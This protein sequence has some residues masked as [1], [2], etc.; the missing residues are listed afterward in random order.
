MHVQG[1]LAAA[2]DRGDVYRSLT[3]LSEKSPHRDASVPAMN[4]FVA[5]GVPGRVH[6]YVAVTVLPALPLP[7]WSAGAPVADVDGALPAVGTP[8]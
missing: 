5:T 1:P 8:S 7:D 6:A 2:S 4:A 3:L